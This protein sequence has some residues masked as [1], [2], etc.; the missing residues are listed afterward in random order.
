MKKIKKLCISLVLLLVIAFCLF[1]ALDREVQE[2]TVKIGFVGPF[3]GALAATGEPVKTGFE[4]AN[5]QSNIEVIYEDDKCN[6]NEA[7][8]AAK[9][10]IE[11]DKVK[12][13]VSGVCSSSTLG[14]APLAEEN[15]V[16]LISPVAAS[17]D[18][19]D[20]GDYVFRVASSSDLM[21]SN[22][23]KLLI[24][25]GYSKIG[26]LYELNDYPVGWKDVF[27]KEFEVLG[28]EIIIEESFN[29]GD[30][31]VKAQLVKIN[32]EDPDA[33]LFT[34]LSVPSAITVLKQS[35][36]LGTDV[37]LIGSE[38]FSFKSVT[39]SNPNAIEGML[40]T[41][42][43]YDL[44]SNE[45]KKFLLD[46]KNKYGKDVTEE[47]YGALGYDTYNL[48]AE[49]IDECNDNTECIKEYLNRANVMVGASGQYV[50]DENGDAIREVV[51]RRVVEG[52]A[53]LS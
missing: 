36:E 19:T 35:N 39:N 20:A 17:P 47:I 40:I 52:K 34:V 4:L 29:S 50:L 44:E 2:D 48:L 27:K 13:L 7:V 5:E 31:D 18:I 10:L 15:G 49:A 30:Q 37:Q 6:V 22:A 9:K 14:M 1:I 38:V 12:I 45:M 25:Q 3:T 23:A 46:Y 32:E 42:Y 51:V 21:A 11:I 33:I 26:I 43:G 41:T 53:V 8:K 24:E 28:G 16:I